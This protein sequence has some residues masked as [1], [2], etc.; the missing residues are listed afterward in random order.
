M[1]HDGQ[2]IQST[3]LFV[4]KMAL[5]RIKVLDSH[6]DGRKGWVRGILEEIMLLEDEAQAIL[7]AQF[8]KGPPPAAGRTWPESCGS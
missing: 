3:R 6:E 7:K 8:I 1:N 4:R 5:I 2:A